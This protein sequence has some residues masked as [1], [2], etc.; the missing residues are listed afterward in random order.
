MLM[1]RF[2]LTL[3]FLLLSP[4]HAQDTGSSPAQDD[5]PYIYYYSGALN[6]IVIER[7]DGTDSRII[8][9]G[10]VDEDVYRI[11]GPGWSPDGRWFAW[12]VWTPDGYYGSPG[13]GYVISAD[14]QTV[15]E[16]TSRFPCVNSMLWHPRENILLVYGNMTKE[17]EY[18]DTWVDPVATYWLI[19]VESQTRLATFS[20]DVTYGRGGTW[21]LWQS[22]YWLSEAERV[23]FFERVFRVGHEVQTLRV[24]M[25]YDGSVTVE[26]SSFEESQAGI[27]GVTPDI[28]A[29][30]DDFRTGFT[31]WEEA[32]DGVAIEQPP[33]NSSAVAGAV[34]RQWHPSG[35]WLLV[36]YEFCKADCLYVTGR[37]NIF[38]PITGHNR[39]IS[40]CGAH[41][42]CVGWLP[43]RVNL[44]EL[45]PGR[46]TPVLPSPVT[47][48]YSHRYWDQGWYTLPD[49]AT[50]QL[51]CSHSVLPHVWNR[52]LLRNIDT[53]EVEFVISSPDVCA[54][55][56]R[57]Y[58]ETIYPAELLVFSLSPDGR[59]YAITDDSEYT[60][61]YDAETGE[62]IAMLNFNGL[63]LSF[64]EDSRTLT[65]VGRFAI[66]TW[67]VDTLVAESLS[68][69]ECHPIP[70]LRCAVYRVS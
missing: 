55:A 22:I 44:E 64:S 57:G 66:A 65:T 60:S 31:F 37:V 36:G 43:R 51:V 14:G 48:D 5:I 61:L 68:Y 39:E 70:R 24:T 54:G 30:N 62:R 42:T 7:A 29:R 67:D 53:S 8:G 12:R 25:A 11:Y 41:P 58:S 9:Q 40:D 47:M 2:L 18:C 3:L 17:G 16:M 1:K 15:L 33:P 32:I 23:Q 49:V 52:S 38:N 69:Q 10:V 59:Y 27:E 28:R 35:N 13:K 45:P 6:G 34:S 50:H 20:I 21:D 56:T 4:V 26:P 63:Q 19:D 46:P